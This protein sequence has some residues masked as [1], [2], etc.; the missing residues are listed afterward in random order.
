MLETLLKH[1]V[2]RKSSLTSVRFIF[3]YIIYVSTFKSYKQ[4]I[5]YKYCMRML[6][7]H[8]LSQTKKSNW[9]KI[10]LVLLQLND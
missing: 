6:I 9:K 7:Y 3:I 2:K 8:T 1:I 10:T 4:S 5:P